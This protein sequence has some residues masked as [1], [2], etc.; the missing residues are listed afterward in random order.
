MR[1]R[2]LQ[3]QPQ[4]PDQLPIFFATKPSS[5]AMAEGGSHLH[6]STQV[7]Y[8]QNQQVPVHR[9]RNQCE[10][11]LNSLLGSRLHIAVNSPTA[12]ISNSVLICS[13]GTIQSHEQPGLS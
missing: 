4:L 9:P 3:V 5:Q 12:E 13:C 8:C 6:R 2:S 10:R 1:T 7:Q 11:E